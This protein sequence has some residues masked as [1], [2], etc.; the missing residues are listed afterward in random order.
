M[1]LEKGKIIVI[2]GSSKYI[3]K[4]HE[5]Q[6]RLTCEGYIVLSTMMEQ[7]P[8]IITEEISETFIENNFKKIRMCDAV[9]IVDVE[10]IDKYSLLLFK[11][12]NSSIVFIS[13]SQ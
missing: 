10:E 6:K 12:S 4:I 5:Q 8:E 3:D 9:Y 1:K 13:T 7:L 11:A 2:T